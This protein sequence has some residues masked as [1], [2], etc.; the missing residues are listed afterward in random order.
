[1][2]KTCAKTILVMKGVFCVMIPFD[3]LSIMAEEFLKQQNFISDGN[4]NGSVQIIGIRGAEIRYKNKKVVGISVFDSPNVLTDKYD[5][6][7][8]AYGKKE[9]GDRFSAVYKGST[10]PGR[11]WTQSSTYSGSGKG[12]PTVQQGQFKYQ[13]GKH[14][15][16]DALVQAAKVVVIR[17]INKNYVIDESDLWDY[18]YGTG[19]NIHAGGISEYVGLN[20]SGCQVIHGG[21]FAKNWNEFKHL[22][23]NVGATQKIYHYTLINGDFFGKWYDSKEENLYKYQNLWYGSHGNKVTELQNALLRKGFYYSS[24]VDTYFG[25]ETHKAVRRFEKSICRKQTGI[26]DYQIMELLEMG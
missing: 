19:I 11:I 7:F 16:K 6:V 15:G 21:W 14:K 25:V 20:S 12:P 9:N 4:K 10:Q 17:D 5:D 3:N 13:K 26:A 24:G 1:M 22:V 8:L 2:S 23:Y 18:P